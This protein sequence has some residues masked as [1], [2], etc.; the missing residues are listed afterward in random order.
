MLIIDC[1]NVR[2]TSLI[3]IMILIKFVYTFIDGP[4]LHIKNFTLLILE[5]EVSL[6][7]QNLLFQF[8]CYQSVKEVMLLIPENI[9]CAQY[10]AC[11]KPHVPFYFPNLPL[12]NE[13]NKLYHL[14]MFFSIIFTNSM[15]LFILCNSYPDHEQ[16]KSVYTA[17]LSAVL[18]QKVPTHPI[19][20]NPSKVHAL[21]GSMVQL[22]E[23]VDFI[24]FFLFSYYS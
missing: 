7:K 6:F 4:L 15:W 10:I 8:Y 9:Q 22:Y 19:W 24:I 18:Q 21:A 2:K 17:Y 5:K 12:N 3:P 13:R 14:L 16:L 20:S 1:T 11:L 23:Q